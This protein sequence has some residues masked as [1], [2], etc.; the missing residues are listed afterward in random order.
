[1]YTLGT[2]RMISA[3]GGLG[4]TVAHIPTYE[5]MMLMM[6][7]MMMMMIMYVCVHMYVCMYEQVCKP[8]HTAQQLCAAATGD[9][10]TFLLGTGK[11]YK[12]F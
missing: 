3:V 7:M 11:P 5:M 8:Q 6:M 2:Q 4:V 12:C 10:S 9:T 1:M